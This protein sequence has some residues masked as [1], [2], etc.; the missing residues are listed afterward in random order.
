[1]GKIVNFFVS[2]YALTVITQL[3]QIDIDYN[4]I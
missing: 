2:A 4:F 1:M 3:A